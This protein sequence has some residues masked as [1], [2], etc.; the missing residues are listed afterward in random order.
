M[1]LLLLS[2]SSKRSS[3]FGP[4]AL[5]GVPD[6]AK[7][8]RVCLLESSPT[9]YIILLHVDVIPVVK[10]MNRRVVELNIQDSSPVVFHRIFCGCENDD[11]NEGHSVQAWIDTTEDG[12]NLHAKQVSAR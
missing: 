4:Y 8:S 2:L 5:N 12:E 7:E 3:L 1:Q 6:G 10:L 9:R 11:D